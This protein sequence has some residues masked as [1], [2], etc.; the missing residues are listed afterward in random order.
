M[1][2][3]RGYAKGVAEAQRKGDELSSRRVLPTG[4]W[5]LSSKG[6]A[7]SKVTRRHVAW[8]LDQLESNK[9]NLLSLQDH[10]YEMDIFCFRLSC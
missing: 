5:F 2:V 1:I 9:S 3:A 8:V 4:G 7:G 10:G 6:H